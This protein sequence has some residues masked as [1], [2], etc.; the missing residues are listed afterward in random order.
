MFANDICSLLCDRR[1]SNIKGKHYAA[2]GCDD[3]TSFPE[4]GSRALCGALIHDGCIWQA[5]VCFAARKLHSPVSASPT[6]RAILAW[7]DKPDQSTLRQVELDGPAGT[8][9]G[10]LAFRRR[11]CVW[12]LPRQTFCPLGPVTDRDACA[13]IHPL[14]QFLCQDL[15]ASN[16]VAA[17][18]VH[19]RAARVAPHG[20][21]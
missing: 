9:H 12:P 20:A 14:V 17:S 18:C 4:D 6:Q 5:I 15:S 3:S 7:S 11:A 2:A 1:H 10:G 16:S 21:S 13:T 8:A 19:P